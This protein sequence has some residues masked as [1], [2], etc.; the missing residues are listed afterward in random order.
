MKNFKILVWALMLMTAGVDVYAAGE[1]VYAVGEGE[2]ETSVNLLPTASRQIALSREE[3]ARR[4]ALTSQ[5]HPLAEVSSPRSIIT[6]TPV[7]DEGMAFAKETESSPLKPNDGEGGSFVFGD[8]VIQDSVDAQVKQKVDE[9]VNS[10][11][12]EKLENAEKDPQAKEQLADEVVD[13]V[14]SGAGLS[15]EQ[16]AKI[17]T[18][19]R[20][21]IKTVKIDEPAAFS[22]WVTKIWKRISNGYLTQSGVDASLHYHISKGNSQGAQ[23]AIDAGADLNTKHKSGLTPLHK[24]AMQG[25]AALVKLLVDAG[26][27]KDVLTKSGNTALSLFTRHDISYNKYDVRNM[28]HVTTAIALGSKLDE[29]DKKGSTALHH[30]VHNG[31]AASV[32]LLVDAGADLNAQDKNGYTAL[33]YAVVNKNSEMVDLL[34]KAGADTKKQDNNGLSPLHAAVINGDA[35]SVDLLLKAGADT[36]TQGGKYNLSPL[37]EALIKGNKDVVQLL[38]KAGADTKTQGNQYNRSPLHSAVVKGDAA[39]VDLL[40]KAGAKTKTQDTDG[41]SPLHSAVMKGDAASVQLLVDAKADTNTQDNDG[42]SPLHSAVSRGNAASVKLL[43]DAGADTKTQD[44]NGHTAL[45]YAASNGDMNSIRALKD[46]GALDDK[47]SGGNTALNRAASRGDIKS[48]IA[49]S[50]AGADV[51]IANN[52]GDTAQVIAANQGKTDA[53]QILKLAGQRTTNRTIDAAFNSGNVQTI[54][55]SAN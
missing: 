35:A 20:Q 21:D 15:P 11:S 42:R 9:I 30:A 43:V 27:D 31:D 8:K 12:Q 34:L 47:D 28:N 38:L 26:A 29:T 49:L 55:A 10:F 53:M 23:K 46:K 32:K 7:Q 52:K 24:A 19:A 50:N 36:N 4:Q 22:K 17:K 39:S 6:S 14:V 1:H 45:D 25:D 33:H 54:L 40:L 37:H 16:T 18:D 44:K 51:N 13:G 3:L 41:L 48:I 2:P 5:E